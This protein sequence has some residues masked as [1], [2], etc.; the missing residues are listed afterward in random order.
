MMAL[1]VVGDQTEE[2]IPEC[3]HPLSR[4]ADDGKRNSVSSSRVG[5]AIPF[6]GR[7]ALYDDDDDDGDDDTPRGHAC[8][9]YTSIP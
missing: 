7:L 4:V 9:L 1:N 5:R 6:A 8:L 2:P 3:L